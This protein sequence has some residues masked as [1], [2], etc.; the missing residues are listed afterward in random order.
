MSSGV[1]SCGRWSSLESSGLK[2]LMFMLDDAVA[3]ADAEVLPLAPVL[4][5]LL[6][7]PFDCP[8]WLMLIVDLR[9]DVVFFQAESSSNSLPAYDLLVTLEE[10]RDRRSSLRESRLQ[11]CMTRFLVTFTTSLQFQLPHSSHSF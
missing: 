5:D 7:W 3:K 9:V 10:K 4:A 11:N 8:S 6:D 2:V 1:N